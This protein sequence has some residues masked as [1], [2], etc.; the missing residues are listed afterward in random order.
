[1]LRSAAIILILLMSSAS[2]AQYSKKANVAH[3]GASAYAPEHTLAAYRLAI[4]MGAEAAD[5]GLTIHPHPTLTE[6]LMES[7]EVVFGQAHLLEV[8]TDRAVV[9]H[10]L[11]TRQVQ[12]IRHG[13]PGYRGSADA[14]PI[15]G[16]PTRW[17]SGRRAALRPPGTSPLP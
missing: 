11:T 4:E 10:D 15:L 16:W 13:C 5:I 9:D 6:T 12:E 17:P 1:M 7:A 3:R 2:S 14:L 8:G